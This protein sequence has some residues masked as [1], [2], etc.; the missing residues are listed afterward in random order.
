MID[1]GDTKGKG[2]KMRCIIHREETQ[3]MGKG[4]YYLNNSK[5]GNSSQGRMILT[6][7]RVGWMI[8]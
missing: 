3:M 1:E 5:R 4:F 8:S 6:C 7:E 2:E